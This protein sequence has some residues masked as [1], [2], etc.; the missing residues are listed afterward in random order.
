MKHQSIVVAFAKWRP[1][2]R[3][4]KNG[5]AFSQWRDLTRGSPTKPVQN[6]ITRPHRLTR[7]WEK[8]GN[9]RVIGK[10][11]PSWNLLYPWR[12]VPSSTDA[13]T[14]LRRYRDR[15]RDPT[16][17]RIFSRERPI[18][19]R[20]GTLHRETGM[21]W[22]YLAVVTTVCRW[23]NPGKETFLH[24]CLNVCHHLQTPTLH[25]SEVSTYR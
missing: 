15:E 14:E 2:L 4:R 22:I 11:T 9:S 6:K 19:S 10:R 25:F 1:F 3:Q 21:T 8:N 7:C 18:V 12:G 16:Y 23:T 20:R 5:R 17:R 13:G 24:C